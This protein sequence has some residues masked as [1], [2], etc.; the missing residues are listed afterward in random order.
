MEVFPL[1]ALHRAELV[2]RCWKFCRVLYWVNRWL[3]HGFRRLLKDAVL[4]LLGRVWWLLQLALS[5]HSLA[6]LGL[7]V[8]LH[9]FRVVIKRKGADWVLR[10]F[11][12][13][14]LSA[15]VFEV[16]LRKHL[17]HICGSGA[18][19]IAGSV[20]RLRGFRHANGKV[21]RCW[22]LVVRIGGLHIHIVS[23]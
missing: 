22:P 12:P 10:L 17:L 15:V 9:H 16:E 8:S 14:H 2:L 13:L 1:L 21:V 18:R 7:H 6:E 23:N 5:L 20:G 19:L 4:A 3:V 11:M